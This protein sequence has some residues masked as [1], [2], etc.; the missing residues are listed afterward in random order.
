MMEPKTRK[1][2]SIDDLPEPPAEILAEAE[3]I[4]KMYAP[5]LKALSK[6]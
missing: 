1:Y 2:R 4:A 3:R 5:L 6:H